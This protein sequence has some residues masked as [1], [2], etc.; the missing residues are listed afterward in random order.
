MIGI[1]LIGLELV[2]W[3]E[4]LEERGSEL[5]PTVGYHWVAVTVALGQQWK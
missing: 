5:A 1:Y 2:V 4:C 3:Q